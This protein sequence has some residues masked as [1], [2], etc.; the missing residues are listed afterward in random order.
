MIKFKR[1]LYFIMNV[2]IDKNYLSTMTTKN[3]L[4]IF[5]F[6]MCTPTPLGS[7]LKFV[8]CTQMFHR[9]KNLQNFFFLNVGPFMLF[10]V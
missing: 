1:C 4:F 9:K 3:I 10:P 6:C 5:N 7:N 2:Q 8:Q